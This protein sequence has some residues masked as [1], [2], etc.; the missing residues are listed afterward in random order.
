MYSNP[1]I[2]PYPHFNANHD[3]EAL[4]NAMKGFGCNNNRVIEILCQRSNAQRQDIARVFKTMYGKD[5]LK[6]LKSGKFRGEFSD[7]L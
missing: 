7:F 4:R 1:S 5:L 3:S 6:E 2:K